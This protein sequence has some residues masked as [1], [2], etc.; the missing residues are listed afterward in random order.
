MDRVKSLSQQ[1]LSLLLAVYIGIFL[2]I[3]VFYRRFDSFSQ[4]IQGIK[5]VSA[6]TEVI[7]IILF[8]FFVMR[9]ISLGGR[10]FYRVVA[11]LLVL[12]SVAASYYMTFFN[13][14][15]GY[16]IVISVLTTDT[17]LSKEVIGLHF[18]IWMVLVSDCLCCLSGRIACG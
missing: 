11:S 6:I 18:I 14:V 1:S 4:G 13:V 5:V 10:F 16:G 17:D 15:I 12:I 7:A 3:S 2:N 9:L 8:T